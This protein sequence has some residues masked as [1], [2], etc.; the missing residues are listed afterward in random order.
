MLRTLRGRLLLSHILPLILVIPLI[1]VGLMYV[2]ESRVLLPRLAQNITGNARLLA[3]ISRTEYD[4]WGNP[5]LIQ[6]MLS[7]TQLDPALRVMFLT[8]SGGLLYS[9][10]VADREYLGFIL[11]LNGLDLAR[12][13]NEVVLTNYSGLRL[14]DI[15]LD[16]LSPVAQSDGPILGIVRVTYH[17][18]SVYEAFWQTRM[19]VAG[20]LAGGLLLGAGIGLTLAVSISRPVQKVTKAIY[21]VASGTRQE[22]LPQRGPIELR[23]QAQAVNHLVARL[24]SLEQARGQLLANLVHELGRPLGALRSAIHALSKGAAQ[25]PQL[26]HD[27]TVGMEEETV[28]LQHVVED[29]AHL[30]DQ[31]LGTLELQRESLPLVDWLPR[32]LG[33]WRVAANEKRLLWQEDIPAELPTIQADP[34]RLAQMVGNLVE[35]AIKYTPPGHAVSISAGEENGRAWIRVSDT[36]PGIPLEEQELI[37]TPFYRGGYGRRIK[38][39]MGL[40]L[41]ITRDLAEAHSGTITLESTPGQGSSFTLWL[42]I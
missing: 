26:L 28:R 1:G 35:N 42:P 36:G 24:H 17:I 27:L 38:Q 12:K 25:D 22:P 10:D 41:S 29:L 21:D 9:T 4:V 11:N 7:R 37:F 5:L 8:P 23:D 19:L 39:G 3:E 6:N 2:L 16:V 31:N 33:H 34:L 32:I 20:L 40:G 14:D 13:G 30:H 15:V 18:D